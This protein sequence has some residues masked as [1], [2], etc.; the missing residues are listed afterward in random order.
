MTT[1]RVTL[2]VV[3]GTL[4]LSGLASAQDHEKKVKRSDLAAAVEKAVVEQSQ[5][6]TI[7]G[8]SQEKRTGTRFTRPS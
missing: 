3:L 4:L 2:C 1:T 5:G 8:F 7:R 6:S